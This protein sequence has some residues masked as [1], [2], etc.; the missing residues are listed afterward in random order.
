MLLLVILHT[1]KDIMCLLH[2]CQVMFEGLLL[3]FNQA[4]K[5]MHLLYGRQA[6]AALVVPFYNVL[7]VLYIHT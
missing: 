1:S 7:D 4:K 3:G 5:V 2:V 6:S